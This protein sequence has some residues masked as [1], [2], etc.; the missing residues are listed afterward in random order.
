MP[1]HSFPTFT[2]S[3]YIRATFRGPL[4][5]FAVGSFD[6]KS[7]RV[8]LCLRIRNWML[9]S[10]FPCACF[11]ILALAG[12]QALLAVQGG[13]QAFSN[14]CVPFWPQQFPSGAQEGD[15]GGHSI[16]LEVRC[17]SYPLPQ[18]LLLKSGSPQSVMDHLQTTANIL[19]LL[20]I[21]INLPNSLLR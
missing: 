12:P 16:P 17:T 6:K 14:F 15:G 5:H 2:S 20:R 18:L 21:T 3:T 10:L 1:C 19:T 11:H 13:P 4:V 8:S 9:F 7:P